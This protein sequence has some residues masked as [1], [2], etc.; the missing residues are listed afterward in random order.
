M[1]AKLESLER[2]L[3]QALWST[4]PSVLTHITRL[5]HSSSGNAVWQSMKPLAV[6]SELD[7]VSFFSVSFSGAGIVFC[8]VLFVFAVLFSSSGAGV[9]VSFLAADVVLAL[10]SSFSSSPGSSSASSSS[11]S[12]ACV[13]FLTVSSSSS[14]VSS[15]GVSSSASRGQGSGQT[16]GRSLCMKRWKSS[17]VD[18]FDRPGYQPGF[19]VM[20]F[21]IAHI[22]SPWH[23]SPLTAVWHPFTLES[24]STMPLVF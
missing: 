2:C 15:S 24:N 16:L 18:L 19:F 13:V 20:P 14:S 12:G 17:N 21:S 23:V 4:N 10:S 7:F 6:L 9:V 3:Y 11:S 8:V 5:W 22:M 1:S